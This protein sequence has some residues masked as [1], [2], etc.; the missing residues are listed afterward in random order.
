[1]ARFAVPLCLLI[2]SLLPA[3]NSTAQTLKLATQ[4]LTASADGTPISHVSPSGNAGQT[5]NDNQEHGKKPSSSVSPGE[6]PVAIGT[7]IRQVAD[8]LERVEAQRKE[9][10]I[11]KFK[12][13]DLTLQ[14]VADKQ[15]GVKLKL[16]MISLGATREYKQTQE[17]VI[18][19]T[20]P[21]GK[22]P[23]SVGAISVTEALE[24]TIISA[25]QGA[26]N[27]GT[28]DYPLSFSGLT[29]TLAFVV[30]NELSGG[31]SIPIITPVTAELSGKVDKANTQTLK[32]TFDDSTTAKKE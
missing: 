28:K 20:P 8:A 29:V 7:V 16:W 15:G 25:A 22:A 12:S 23:L 5:I 4:L 26:Q 27:A 19:L 6:Q 10:Q 24:S 31:A 14:T 32:V 13:V 21:T 30:Q 18:H 2:S 9:L 1:M 17:L 3:A 11:P